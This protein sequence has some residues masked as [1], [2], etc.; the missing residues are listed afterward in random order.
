MTDTT[1]AYT[2]ADDALASLV[3]QTIHLLMDSRGYDKRSDLHAA[4]MVELGDPD[5][6][7][8]D[9]TVHDYC[10]HENLRGERDE[11]GKLPFVDV[12]L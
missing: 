7:V 3:L 6:A 12:K 11:D 8:V 4:V 2:T 10:W 5:E 9:D 1:R